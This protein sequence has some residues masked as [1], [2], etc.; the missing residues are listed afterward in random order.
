MTFH[1]VEDREVGELAAAPLR[2]AL[3]QA[4]TVPMLAVERAEEVERLVAAL[5][6]WTVTDRQANREL[7]IQVGPGGVQQHAGAPETVWVLTAPDGRTRAA[8][9]TTS[10]A[11][12]SDRYARWEGFR[13]ALGA[14]LDAVRAVFNPA[15]CTRLGAR[16][17]NELHDERAS[18]DPDLLAGL[19]TTELIAPALSLGR[20]LVSSLG[21]LRV[22]EDDDVVFALR[23]GLVAPGTYLLDF[24]VYREVN[25]DFDSAALVQRAERF[26]A[27]IESVFGWALNDDY[28]EELRA[29]A[30]DTARAS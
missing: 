12:E 5:D 22:A 30:P 3:V 28:L 20:P 19:L 4:R 15:R 7:A 1:P 9:S 8:V 21:E 16:Y 11:L 2:L 14:L 29:G 23:H 27:R 18:G 24:D 13:D 10:V 25:E 6:G 17:V 26:H